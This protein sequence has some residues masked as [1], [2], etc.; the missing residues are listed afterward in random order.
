MQSSRR[1]KLRLWATTKTA[2]VYVAAFCG[3]GMR[4][5]HDHTAAVA[6]VP[7]ATTVGGSKYSKI[8]TLATALQFHLHRSR[9]LPTQL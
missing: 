2:H 8:P 1:C 4:S 7:T 6:A 9:E 3:G 5:R